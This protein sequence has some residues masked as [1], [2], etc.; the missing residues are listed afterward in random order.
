MYSLVL[1]APSASKKNIYVVVEIPTKISIELK[2]K[3]L[4][5]WL[6]SSFT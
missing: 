6:K 4:R 1:R 3:D 5:F 2:L